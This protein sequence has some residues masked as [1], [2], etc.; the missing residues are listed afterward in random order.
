M[1]LPAGDKLGLYEILASLGAGGM[2]EP[3]VDKKDLKGFLD[4][5]SPQ[6]RKDM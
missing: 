1:P 5:T 2:G 6:S 3:G 4:A